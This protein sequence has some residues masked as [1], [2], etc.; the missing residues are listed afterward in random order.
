M[1]GKYYFRSPISQWIWTRNHYCHSYFPHNVV[2]IPWGDLQVLL[3]IGPNK[4][5]NLTDFSRRWECLVVMV[6]SRA[7]I[8]CWT[9]WVFTSHIISLSDYQ[10]S[11]QP[12]P[13]LSSPVQS[14]ANSVLSCFTIKSRGGWWQNLILISSLHSLQ[15][16]KLSLLPDVSSSFVSPVI[17]LT[18]ILLD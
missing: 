4:M 5:S 3:M 1:F 6:S 7:R 17:G 8:T 16:G 9:I 15:P 11:W 18:G 14:K 13:V 2:S 10:T 12:V